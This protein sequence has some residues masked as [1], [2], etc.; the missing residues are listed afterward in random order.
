MICR[1]LAG[2]TICIVYIPQ[3]M[4]LASEAEVLSPSPTAATTRDVGDECRPR[5]TRPTQWRCWKLGPHDNGHPLASFSSSSS[6]ST[7]QRLLQ[8]SFQCQ[9]EPKQGPDPT[10]NK[11][12]NKTMDDGNVQQTSK[13]KNDVCFA[14][15]ESVDY[16]TRTMIRRR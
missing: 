8:A 3:S 4:Q 6:F 10:A 5:P 15:R 14:L 2:M 1:L 11:Q 9:H 7:F 16:G 12:P 13:M